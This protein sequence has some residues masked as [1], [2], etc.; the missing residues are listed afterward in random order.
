MN[1]FE[2]S[3]TVV[4]VIAQVLIQIMVE[5]FLLHR[6]IK[7]PKLKLFGGKETSQHL[8]DWFSLCHVVH[9][10]IFYWITGSFVIAAIIEVSWEI[11]ENTPLI[12]DRYRRT[13]EA[14]YSG[15]TIVNSVS[16]VV[17]MLIGFTVA[18]VIPA[19]GTAGLVVGLEL[20]CLWAIRNNL[21]L[22]ILMLIHPFGCIKRWQYKA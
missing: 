20:L 6:P 21:T 2:I 19:W 10:L 22:D 3:Q 16:D 12:I 11:A 18:W 4:C 9:G 15:D 8:L 13:S 14:S 5:L 17:C 1:G 7:P